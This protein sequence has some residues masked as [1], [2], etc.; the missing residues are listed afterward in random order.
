MSVQD[1]IWFLQGNWDL[2]LPV[3]ASFVALGE[4]VVRLTPTKT[5]D[6]FVTRIGVI[7]EKV[8]NA[9]KVPNNVKP[10]Q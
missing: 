2:F 10:P 5:D 9:L 8:L 3:V 1:L 7:I 4:A 6:G